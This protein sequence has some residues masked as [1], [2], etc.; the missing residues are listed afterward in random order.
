[1]FNT[2]LKFLSL[3]FFSI[4][5]TTAYPAEPD[6]LDS[7]DNL[8]KKEKA[9]DTNTINVSVPV[10]FKETDKTFGDVIEDLLV[11][12]GEHNFR[13]NQ[14]AHI[15]RAIAERNKS[16]YFSADVLHFC[17]L[18][19]AKELL[20]IAPDYLLRMP[21]RISIRQQKNKNTRIEVWL[22]PEDDKRTIEFA[23]KINTILK[24]I[25]NYGAS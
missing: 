19:Y 22:L 14:H 20:D 11:I 17:N 13:L 9:E 25:V 2:L 15:G 1:M 24:K 3:L 23:K 21:C 4:I 16:P 6:N 8:N 18:S 12:I 10:Y 7:P 5:A